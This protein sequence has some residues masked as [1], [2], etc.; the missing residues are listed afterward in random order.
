MAQESRRTDVS[1]AS[2]SQS[3]AY[4]TLRDKDEIRLLL[5][6]PRTW[7]SPDG[8]SEPHCALKHIKFSSRSRP[9]YEALSYM[10]GPPEESQLIYVNE[11]PV[12]IRA[13]LHSALR[14]LQLPSEP[15]CLWVDALCINQDDVEERN[16]QVAQMGRIYSLARLVV[17]WVGDSDRLSDSAMS[18][19][20]TWNPPSFDVW[21]PYLD[22]RLTLH[23]LTAVKSF[24][25]RAYWERL[26]IIQE[27][28]LATNIVVQ[29]GHHQ[30]SWNDFRRAIDNIE[31]HSRANG[32]WE[33]NYSVFAGGLSKRALT[34][35]VRRSIPARLCRQK[36]GMNL[37]YSTLQHK[38]AEES[39]YD[40]CLK[41]VQVHESQR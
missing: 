27:I 4:N 20:S 33:A 39:L 30:T 22:D 11:V 5:L 16:H 23:G 6:Q 26:W 31:S 15:R 14:H 10:W 35:D 36:H 13:N 37:P 8:T 21:N 29:C 1:G 12:R 3:F 19:F 38:A 28:V 32:G 7:S 2:S 18:L 9:K 25:Y 34:M 17:A 41:Y 40:L 24:C